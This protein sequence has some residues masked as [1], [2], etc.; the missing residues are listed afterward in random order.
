MRTMNGPGQTRLHGVMNLG[1]G[2]IQMTLPCLRMLC[3]LIIREKDFGMMTWAGELWV[4]FV[5]I[6][7]Y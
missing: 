3:R 5:N 4:T 1:A 7:K 2:E 6:R